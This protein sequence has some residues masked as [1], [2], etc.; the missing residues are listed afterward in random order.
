MKPSSIIIDRL[1]NGHKIRQGND[2]Y[3]FFVRS[4]PLE[5]IY[6]LTMVDETVQVITGSIDQ[7]NKVASIHLARFY[8]NEDDVGEHTI[9]FA[10]NY[11]EDGISKSFIETRNFIIVDEDEPEILFGDNDDLG[12]DSRY[13][14]VVFG[15]PGNFISLTLKLLFL[16]LVMLLMNILLD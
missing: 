4:L 12:S 11:L 16:N 9:T 14:N 15:T 7:A 1:D 10:I 3:R 5:A 13:P 6:G 8:P 2:E